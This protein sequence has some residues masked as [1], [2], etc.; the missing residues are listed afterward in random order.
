MM[1]ATMSVAI[2]GKT[3]PLGKF[4][5][6]EVKLNRNDKKTKIKLQDEFVR[7][8]GAYDS[9]LTYPAYTRDILAEIVRLTG[10]TTDANIQ[11][12]ND[13]VAKKLEKTS[14]REA[15]VTWRNYQE[16]LL[17]LIVMG[18]LILSS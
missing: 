12:V 3:V 17:D 2:A 13:Q 9:Q 8:S 10:I 1:P 15:L 5:V 16:A 7:L 11:L 4:F 14:Y 6:T 18:S